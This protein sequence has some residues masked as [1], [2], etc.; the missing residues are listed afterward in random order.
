[1]LYDVIIIGGGPSGLTAAVYASRAGLST[2]LIEKA[3]CGGQMAI[4]DLLENYPGFNGINGFELAMKFEAQ[5]KEFGTEIIYDEVLELE[6]NG[7]IK[8]VITVNDKYSARTVIIAAGTNV[9]RLDISGEEKFIGSGI[10]FC[11]TCDAPFFRDK[12]ILV[13]GGGD[14]ALQ[15]AI[16][17]AKFA[18]NVT[19]VH[20]RDAFRAAK[21]LRERILTYPNISIMYNTIPQEIIGTDAVEGVKLKNMKTEEIRILKV[22]GVFVFIGLIPNTGFISYMTLDEFGYIITDD[23]MKTSIKGVFA[24]GDIRKKDLRQIVTAASDGAQAAISA[25]YYIEKFLK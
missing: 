6:L 23:N 18:K 4:T 25:Q 21:I 20:R 5:A 3:G 15:E 12:D 19:I 13:V 22:Q 17:L 9:K 7:D 1:M 11:A 14:S 16:Y 2:L 8:H 10:S 24:C